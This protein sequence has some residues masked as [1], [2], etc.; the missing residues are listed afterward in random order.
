MSTSTN[1]Q[2]VYKP[3]GLEDDSSLVS[4]STSNT[5]DKNTHRIRILTLHA[6]S[7]DSLISCDLNEVPLSAN[8]KYEALSYV[9]GDEANKLPAQVAGKTVA[10]TVNLSIALHHLRLPTQSRTLWVDALC[11]NQQDL[12]ERSSQVQLMGEIFGAASCVLIWLGEAVESS[13][14][15]FE[16]VYR[17]CGALKSKVW[18]RCARATGQRLSDLNDDE[19]GKCILGHQHGLSPII[20]KAMI[21]ICAHRTLSELSYHPDEYSVLA[22]VHSRFPGQ[23]HL[24]YYLKFGSLNSHQDLFKIS[25]ALHKTFA[26]RD[27]WTR[28]WV[29][30]EAYFARRSV[31]ICGDHQI[32]TSYMTLAL[33]AV[34]EAFMQMRNIPVQQYCLP[35]LSW[36]NETTILIFLR[37]SYYFSRRETLL[38]LVKNVSNRKAKD[39]RDRIFAL[40]NLR[41]TGCFGAIVPDYRKSIQ[42][43]FEE[44]T[45]A[46]IIDDK[47]LKVLYRF[48]WSREQDHWR[49]RT[50]IPSWVPCY[51]SGTGE[52][53][54]PRNWYKESF[55]WFS[56]GG[57]S[58][59]EISSLFQNSFLR[60]AAKFVDPISHISA[61]ILC[62]ELIGE[63]F[64]WKKILLE[65]WNTHCSLNDE[66]LSS[67]NNL[68]DA[69][70]RTCLRD[71]VWFKEQFSRVRAADI[72][73]IQELFFHILHSNNDELDEWTIYSKTN[74]GMFTGNMKLQVE[75][76][77][78][79][80]T[81][82]GYIG[83]VPEYVHLNDH[84][85][86]VP[87]SSM[88][89][90]LRPGN[91]PH[92]FTLVG[93][94]YIHGVMDGELMKDIDDGIEP[95]ETIWL[96]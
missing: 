78:L 67:G 63:D 53:L 59:L 32:C 20:S 26:E 80:R 44:T 71:A 42:E 93:P 6:G 7:G 45:R 69:F 62:P 90:V 87:G 5:K 73:T 57:K 50:S 19:V 37:T 74:V 36:I 23:H 40:L 79:I 29:L 47:S 86:V 51:G 66:Y 46:I 12:D 95:G 83:L 24:G 25:D 81:E 38:N 84:L 39:P 13:K 68:T 17:I 2:Y 60:L 77:R 49:H 88:P 16:T 55:E 43:V 4:T 9:W 91:E 3:L 27:W 92:H 65:F 70:V 89:L 48:G 34:R 22:L 85:Y 72:A 10:I 54:T 31:L 75:R 76:S 21:D 58:D 30:Q 61:S 28:I 11:I 94:A 8:P 1:D 41:R 15:A 52:E 35:L 64:H 18:M 56:A 96:A 82:K 33:L 14:L